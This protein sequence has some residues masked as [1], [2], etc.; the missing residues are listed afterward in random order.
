MT[1]IRPRSTT[2]G[3]IAIA[4]LAVRVV[5]FLIRR[6]GFARTVRFLDAMPRVGSIAI[7]P[8]PRWT[9]EIALASAGRYGGTCLDRSVLLWF[10]LRQHGLEGDLRIGVAYDNGTIDGHAWVEYRGT[11]LNDAPDIAE[12]FAVFDDDPTTLVFT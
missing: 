5:R 7:A 6:T 1:F 10:V 9:G 11:V 12:R 2:Y 3:R 8:D 4:W